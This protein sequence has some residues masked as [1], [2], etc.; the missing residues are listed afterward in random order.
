MIV[1]KSI[2]IRSCK[3]GRAV[4]ENACSMM[5]RKFRIL[6]KRIEFQLFNLARVMQQEVQQEKFFRNLFAEMKTVL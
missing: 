6:Y 4:K 5:K 2:L 3:G 1:S